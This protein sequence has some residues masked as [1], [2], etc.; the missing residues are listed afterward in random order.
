MRLFDAILRRRRRAPRCVNVYL[1][2]ENAIVAPMHRNIAG[3]YFEQD[4]AVVV[5]DLHDASALG[6]EFRKAFDRFSIRDKNLRNHRRSDWPAWQAS[7]LRTIKE[8]ERRYRVVR[9][10]GVDDDN[11][12]VRACVELPVKE[13][14]GHTIEFA[15]DEPPAIIG[16]RLHELL[17]P[18][19][20]A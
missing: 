4:V 6:R 10:H 7:G 15:V 3:V 1:S 12:R 14:G 18:T 8:F 13:D 2:V 9:C 11:L 20:V 5:T 17:A 19:P 16:A